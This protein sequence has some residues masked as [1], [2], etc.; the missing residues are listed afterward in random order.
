M[1]ASQIPSTSLG[2]QAFTPLPST[3][4]QAT[5]DQTTPAP[6]PPF[7]DPNTLAGDSYEGSQESA[8][9]DDAGYEEDFAEEEA[10]PQTFGQKIH[11]FATSPIGIGLEVVGAIALGFLVKNTFLK[12]ASKEVD[13]VVEPVAEILKPA[14]EA[15]EA[16]AK[17]IKPEKGA[18][19]M[20]NKGSGIKKW[21]VDDQPY[22]NNNPVQRFL[23]RRHE[24]TQAQP[25]LTKQQLAEASYNKSAKA[26]EG[27]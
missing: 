11:T 14:E 10:P 22:K 27:A 25:G 23:K 6:L 24:K 26:T 5:P 3:P 13:K 15:V 7:T 20:Y 8:S 21:Q 19:D 2:T 16:I 17:D 18:N 4:P 1:M 12:K 9:G